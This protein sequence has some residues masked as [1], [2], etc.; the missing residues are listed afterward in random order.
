MKLLLDENLPVKLKNFFSNKHRVSTV[1]DM[2]EWSG[3]KNGELLGLMTLRGFDC[4]VTV[5]KN[6]KYQQNLNKF[7]I[8]IIILNAPDNKLS[9]LEPFITELEQKV[10]ASIDKNVIKININ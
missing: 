10:S 6:L 8:K 2:E 5:D 4:L 7:D 3:K 1:S 9:T